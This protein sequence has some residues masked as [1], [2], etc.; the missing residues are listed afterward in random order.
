VTK[1]P[2]KRCRVTIADLA[3]NRV[4][5]AVCGLEE[6]PRSVDA[7]ELKIALGGAAERGSK[8]SRQGS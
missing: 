4:D 6:P 7:A 8:P 1:D 3:S 5:R 2:P